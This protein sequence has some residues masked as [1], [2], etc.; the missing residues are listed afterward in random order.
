[1]MR[2]GCVVG[3]LACQK[4]SY[5]QALN[6]EVLSCVKFA[7]PEN[8]S[9]TPKK[10]K[11]DL[12]GS[13]LP[14]VWLVEFSDSILFPEGGGQPSDQGTISLSES[15]SDSFPINF[16]ERQGL[17]CIYH[18]PKP[19][20]PGTHVRQTVD[21][22]RR[23]DHMQQ[24]TGQHLLSAVMDK[25]DNL[26]TLGWGMGSEGGMN[27]VD[28]PRTPTQEEIQ[29]IQERCNQL[30]RQTIPITV[31][32]V[33]SNVSTDNLPSDYDREK[34]IIRAI[35]I[36][37]VDVNQCCG[38]HLA[39]TSEIALILLHHTQ[40]VHSKNCRLFFTAGD[41]AIKL[42]STSISSLRSVAKLVGSST[43]PSDILTSL[44]KNNDAN[45]ELRRKEK[46]LLADIAKYEADIAKVALAG[47][48]KAFV[49]RSSEG[50]DF[51]KMVIQEIKDAI[52]E[53]GVV[54]LAAGEG[55]KGGPIVVAGEKTAVEHMITKIK[56]A[57]PNVK[58]GGSNGKWQGKV[59]IWKKGEVDLLRKLVDE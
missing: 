42:A 10:S 51:V 8:S 3:A 20:S 45:V 7:P 34:G 35:R 31:E 38:T 9:T 5:L 11:K 36:G 30:I 40:P 14:D 55:Q 53:R 57:M 48:A 58:G 28:L 21:F 32:I 24:H 22:G 27:Y 56:E 1:M 47:R 12:V 33:D 37:D 19:L 29:S 54:V 15:E 16:V 25:C 18:C 39:R 4:D 41:R 52:G 59:P 49:Y 43:N 6:A 23:W 44:E 2:R 50:L 26:E 46:K 13:N 17:Q